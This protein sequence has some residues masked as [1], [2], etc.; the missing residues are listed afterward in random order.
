MLVEIHYS[1]VAE[2]WDY[3]KEG[4]EEAGLDEALMLAKALADKVD[5]LMCHNPKIWFFVSYKHCDVDP[6]WTV[7]HVHHGHGL[8]SM[9]SQEIVDELMDDLKAIAEK[10]GRKYIL[11]NDNSYFVKRF[12]Q[13]AG[14]EIWQP[15]N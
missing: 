10:F 14:G 5:V 6:E 2:T 8:E 15:V 4:L 3:I 13:K 1:K 7:M 11:F 12:R 9:Y